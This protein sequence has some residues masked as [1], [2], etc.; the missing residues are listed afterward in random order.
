MKMIPYPSRL[1]L[2]K[3]LHQLS[4]TNST[5]PAIQPLFF[6]DSSFNPI[7]FLLFQSISNR[8]LSLTFIT[9]QSMHIP[10]MNQILLMFASDTDGQFPFMDQFQNLCLNW[11]REDWRSLWESLYQFIQEFLCRDL[12]MERI[13]T[14]LD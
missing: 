10:D 9:Q 12:E 1:S 5:T 2:I 3:Q 6:P 8:L 4:R 14:I 13:T 11:G 7:F